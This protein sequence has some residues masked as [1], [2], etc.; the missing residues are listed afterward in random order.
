MLP[1]P[2]EVEI[3]HLG[4][5][6]DTNTPTTRLRPT[7]PP[8]PAELPRLN[9]ADR[10]RLAGAGVRQP[11]GPATGARPNSRPAAPPRP[12][13][14]PVDPESV[15]LALEEYV[16]AADWDTSRT[17][18]EQH[19]EL[20]TNTALMLLRANVSRVA[21]KVGPAASQVLARYLQTLEVAQRAGIDFAFDRM[22]WP[23]EAPAADLDAI[24]ARLEAPEAVYNLDERVALVEE[25]SYLASREQDDLLGAALQ[26]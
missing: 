7:P 20:L 23:H 8:Q 10:E 4:R 17:V 13:G 16:N 22:P 11:Y 24:L 14:A 12:P 5:M 15:A 19:P 1:A 6:P 3:I 2:N 18:V 21:E 26:R 9:P 25:A